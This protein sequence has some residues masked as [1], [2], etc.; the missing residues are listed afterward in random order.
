MHAERT[1]SST[2]SSPRGSFDGARADLA[3]ARRV[4]NSNDMTLLSL[5]GGRPL[6]PRLLSPTPRLLSP[7]VSGGSSSSI[8]DAKAQQRE[9]LIASWKTVEADIEAVG[10]ALM[11]AFFVRAPETFV[12]FKF[13]ADSPTDAA[14]LPKMR[15]HSV[16][17]PLPDVH[18]SSLTHSAL[19]QAFL[20]RAIGDAI[21]RLESPPDP[22]PFVVSPDSEPQRIDCDMLRRLGKAHSRL[23]FSVRPHVASMGGALQDALR[24]C[25]GS[26]AF[27]PALAAS[28]RDHF[29]AVAACMLEGIDAGEAEAAA[30]GA[31]AKELAAK[32]AAALGAGLLTRSR[33]AAE[34][35][36]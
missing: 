9:T 13:G 14:A 23:A 4:S 34:P 20:L 3:R 19:S 29:D 18:L 7:K 25:L 2:L 32:R 16:C 33:D 27:T 5:G 1:L 15:A 12:H 6:P 11:Q 17:V 8:G 31:K 26:L 21:Q 10:V 24:T 35:V 28:W 30:E 22:F 36:G